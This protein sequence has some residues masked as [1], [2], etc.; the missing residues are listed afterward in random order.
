MS[1]NQKPASVY[2][3]SLQGKPEIQVWILH[4]HLAVTTLIL[5]FQIGEENMEPNCHLGYLFCLCTS[6]EVSLNSSFSY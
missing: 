2:F 6:I 1:L 4:L 3:L 5:I